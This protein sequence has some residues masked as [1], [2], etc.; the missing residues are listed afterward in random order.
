MIES[1]DVILIGR[2][3]PITEDSVAI[4]MLVDP[5]RE[6]AHAA[7]FHRWSDHMEAWDQWNVMG[8]FGPF[9][10]WEH[11]Y[12]LTYEGFGE[13]WCPTLSHMIQYTPL[14]GIADPIPV[15]P[16][17]PPILLR[18]SELLAEPERKP[19]VSYAYDRL[20]TNTMRLR[21]HGL[22][23]HPEVITRKGLDALVRSMGL[24]LDE[25]D[26]GWI[27][28]RAITPEEERVAL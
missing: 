8:L 21:K 23:D 2:D 24:V 5:Y 20:L 10:K 16:V 12:F 17:N 27:R 26:K 11:V 9:G 19:H 28:L 13:H 22:L 4:R 25:D 18:A 15:S 1:R 7:W 6:Q 14:V 3:E